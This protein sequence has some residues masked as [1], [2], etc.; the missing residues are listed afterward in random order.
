MESFVFIVIQSFRPFLSGL[1]GY[2]R[3]F[4]HKSRSLWFPWILISSW[5]NLEVQRWWGTGKLVVSCYPK[6]T[7]AGVR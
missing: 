6:S 7:Y 3:R 2:P 5:L 4:G 1:S